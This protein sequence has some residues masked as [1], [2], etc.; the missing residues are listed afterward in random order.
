ME[1]NE[2]VKFLWKLAA[3]L[4]TS[5]PNNCRRINNFQVTTEF[6]ST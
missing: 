1:F 5:N 3:H 4:D 2:P 6:E